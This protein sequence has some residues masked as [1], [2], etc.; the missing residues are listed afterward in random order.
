MFL[1]HRD[2]VYEP[3]DWP[4]GIAAW[5]YNGHRYV[6]IHGGS[7]DYSYDVTDPTDPVLLHWGHRDPRVGIHLVRGTKGYGARSDFAGFAVFDFTDPYYIPMI[8]WYKN[9]TPLTGTGHPC[10]WVNGY[11]VTKVGFSGREPGL[12]IYH[13]IYDTIPEP[14]D[15]SDTSTHYLEWV[16]TVY[17]GPELQFS[18]KSQAHVSFSLFNAS[19]QRAYDQDLGTLGPGPHTIPLPG[20]KPGVYFLELW[21]N[22]DVMRKKI[23]FTQEGGFYH[24]EDMQDNS[25]PRG[26]G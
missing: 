16:R 25:G 2:S 23:I 15:T 13:Y 17:G 6:Y 22:N 21:I 1:V 4:S 5:E 14:P 9:D 3:Y 11:V 8:A 24:E 19:G 10:L 7:Y 20:L 18:L 26:H 12:A